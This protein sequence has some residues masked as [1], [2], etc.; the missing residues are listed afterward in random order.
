MLEREV[1]LPKPPSLAAAIPLINLIVQNF[2]WIEGQAL[3]KLPWLVPTLNM[4]IP[5]CLLTLRWRPGVL[6][7]TE[8]FYGGLR[9]TTAQGDKFSRRATVQAEVDRL[10]IH[11]IG[12]I[13]SKG[14]H[15][16]RVY[17]LYQE[18]A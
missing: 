12:G 17:M 5:F 2:F 18:A 3:I 15:D 7:G 9:K 10:A 14:G 13:V 4:K 11:N 6:K 1:V 16:K 8:D